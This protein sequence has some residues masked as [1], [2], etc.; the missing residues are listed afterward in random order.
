[1]YISINVD[2]FFF[3]GKERIIK[4]NGTREKFRIAWFRFFNFLV[5]IYSR[6]LRKLEN[7]ILGILSFSISITKFRILLGPIQFSMKRKSGII[8][9]LI[10]RPEISN[11]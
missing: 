9:I 8:S 10:L 11:G 3:E 1:M 6:K 2:L 7:L 5:E 4:R